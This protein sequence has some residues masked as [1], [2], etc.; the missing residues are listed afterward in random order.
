MDA[1]GGC[2]HAQVNAVV[3]ADELVFAAVAETVHIWPVDKDGINFSAEHSLHTQSD[4]AVSSL[5]VRKSTVF[6]ACGK[7]LFA[8]SVDTAQS[9]A[10]FDLSHS[11]TSIS[12]PA[13]S[14]VVIVLAGEEVSVLDAGLQLL[15]TV[16]VL[17]DRLTSIMLHTAVLPCP[18]EVALSAAVQLLIH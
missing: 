5:A 14:S 13:N 9:L 11:I 17:Q 10:R 16:G 4:S 3:V 2:C 6:A 8:L 15:H 18:Y 12:A 1:R 7:Q